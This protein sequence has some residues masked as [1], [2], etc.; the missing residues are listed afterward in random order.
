VTVGQLKQLLEDKKDEQE[1]RLMIQPTYPLEHAVDG[2]WQWE[3]DEAS[4]PDDFFPAGRANSVLY[5]L[6]GEQKGYGTRRAWDFG[7]YI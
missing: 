6:E 4:D 7:E 3:Y 1:V 2:V 5:L